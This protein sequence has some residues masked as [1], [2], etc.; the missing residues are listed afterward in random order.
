MYFNSNANRDGMKEGKVGFR[1]TIAECSIFA[2]FHFHYTKPGSP[3]GALFEGG[4]LY[5]GKHLESGDFSQGE[6]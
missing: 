1:K 2:D 4:G 3:H 6:T 5:V